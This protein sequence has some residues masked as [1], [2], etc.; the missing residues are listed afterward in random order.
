MPYNPFTV[1]CPPKSEICIQWVSLPDSP[2]AGYCIKWDCPPDHVKIDGLC[3]SS[4]CVA[5]NIISHANSIQTSI[6]GNMLSFSTSVIGNQI[7]NNTAEINQEIRVSE[8]N[9]RGGINTQTQYLTGLV[10][11]AS[12][13]VENAINDS[14]IRLGRTF[15]DTSLVVANHIS[16]RVDDL[17]RTLLEDIQD[18]PEHINQSLGE[19]VD[20]VTGAGESIA[21]NIASII[22]AMRAAIETAIETLELVISQ[23]L[24]AIKSTLALG[25]GLVADAIDAAREFVQTAISEIT[26]TVS[27]DW[28]ISVGAFEDIFSQLYAGE[29][30]TWDEF[31]TAFD[32]L[33]KGDTIFYLILLGFLFFPTLIETGKLLVYPILSNLQ[34]LATEKGRPTQLTPDELFTAFYRG[35]IPPNDRDEQLGLLG[36]NP[37]RIEQLRRVIKPLLNLMEVRN[38]YLRHQIDDHEHNRLLGEYGFDETQKQQITFLYNYI[39]PAQDLILMAVREVFTPDIAEAYGLFED[40]PDE[41]IN[42]AGQQGISREWAKNYWGAHWQLPSALMGFEMFH[43]RVID[44]EELTVLLRAL[45]YMPHWRDKL[46]EISYRPLTRV[47]VRRMHKTGILDETEL[48]NAYLD[49]GFSPHNAEKMTAFTI[50]YNR[51]GVD[52]T[53]ATIK[54]LTVSTVMRA[55]RERIITYDDAIERLYYLNYSL[56]DAVLLLELGQLSAKTDRAISRRTAMEKR[57]VQIILDGYETQ[58]ISRTEAL[59]RLEQHGYNETEAGVLLN[60]EEE[61]YQLKLK[62]ATVEAIK[63]MYTQGTI[64]PTTFRGILAEQMFTPL[65]IDRI[66]SEVQLILNLRT[67]QPT[68][69][70]LNRALKRGFLTEEQYIRELQGL[71]YPDKVIAMYISFLAPKEVE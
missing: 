59:T 29:F 64:D 36:Y 45:D 34:I 22:A 60:L 55:Y 27:T 52:E 49:V 14:E 70:E 7:A 3:Y 13:D 62:R 39:P 46:I 53:E 69:G 41:F 18:I 21:D 48:Y 54:Q 61:E 8:N 11:N 28:G 4:T 33:L 63:E 31:K 56:D 44:R 37:D 67:R 20:D 6:I 26:E 71:G 66:E 17:E 57:L 35:V 9:I 16:S 24:L 19:F 32:E 23:T 15:N 12:I 40:L 47:D 30:E 43:R 42:W 1:G 2:L 10:N 65:E 58:T 38:L 25:F 68:K 51:V 5:N 50:K